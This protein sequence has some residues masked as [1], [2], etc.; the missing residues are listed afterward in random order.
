MTSQG[1]GG[2][3]SAVGDQRVLGAEP[4]EPG[5]V[6]TLKIIAFLGLF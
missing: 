2:F 5:D 3:P 4:A 1:S 6:Y